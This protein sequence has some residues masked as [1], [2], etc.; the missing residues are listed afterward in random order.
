M[1]SYVHLGNA[2]A[3]WYVTL[4]TVFVLDRYTPYF[5]LVDIFDQLGHLMTIATFFGFLTST[6]YYI[7]P[8]LQGH[9]LRM[10]G[11]M[12][13][14]FVS[15][16]GQ[17]ERKPSFNLNPCHNIQRSMKPILENPGVMVKLSSWALVSV[18]ESGTLM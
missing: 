10:S 8:I 4:A 15:L 17:K 16:F 6:W 5:K 14:D 3:G 9:S 2:L 1:L 18:H 7:V 12:I 11:N 13:Y